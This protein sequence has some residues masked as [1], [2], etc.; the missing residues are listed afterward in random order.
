MYYLVCRVAKSMP[1]NNDSS[2][3]QIPY[4][5]FVSYIIYVL[6]FNSTHAQLRQNLLYLYSIVYSLPDYGLVEA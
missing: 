3:V 4:L 5:I 2:A 6:Y 1:A